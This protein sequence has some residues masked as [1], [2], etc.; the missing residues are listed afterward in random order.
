MSS[1]YTDTKEGA[2]QPLAVKR[3]M[4]HPV[5]AIANFFIDRYG[6]HGITPLKLQKL[7][8]VAHGWHLALLDK[9]LVID[10]NPRRG[11]M[12][13]FSP[14][15]I[16]NSEALDLSPLIAKRRTL[17]ALSVLLSQKSAGMT[18]E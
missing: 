12:V 14:L 15:C 16:M 13:R 1:Q 4:G 18:S 6:R 7:I 5:K 10:E 17:T 2:A 8:Y 11:D 9:P 3:D